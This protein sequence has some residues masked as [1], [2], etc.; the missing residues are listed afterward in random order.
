MMNSISQKLAPEQQNALKEFVSHLPRWKQ[1]FADKINMNMLR[2]SI[3]VF[4]NSPF[5][6]LPHGEHWCWNKSNGKV[7]V[8]LD[9]NTELTLQKLNARR[10]SEE[11]IPSLKVWV[12][13][14]KLEN[15]E[16][17]LFAFWCEKGYDYNERRTANR[18]S[19]RINTVPEIS[20][21]T[22]NLQDFSF[23]A[24]FS[25]PKVASEFGWV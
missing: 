13:Q 23:L 17:H 4:S 1:L 19:N 10:K 18:S 14:L 20:S 6:E 22:L 3:F 12:F 5:G 25:D 21:Q 8:Q 16:P 7:T 2:S 9:S 11:P 24:P 15:E